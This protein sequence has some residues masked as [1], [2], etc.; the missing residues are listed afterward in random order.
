MK[1]IKIIFG[2]TKIIAGLFFAGVAWVSLTAESSRSVED[3][4]I[5]SQE[6][7]GTEVNREVVTGADLNREDAEK[8]PMIAGFA[9]VGA[10]IFVIWG[11]RDMSFRN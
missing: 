1:I 9:I 10:A 11:C 8:A 7:L 2:L 4:Y 3:V 6:M 5:R